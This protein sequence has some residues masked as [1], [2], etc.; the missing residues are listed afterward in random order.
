M[1]GRQPLRAFNARAIRELS[2]ATAN[3][4]ALVRRTV[5]RS[6]LH[7]IVP[8]AEVE[9]WLRGSRQPGGGELVKNEQVPN[10]R[11][12]RRRIAP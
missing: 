3:D 11:Q 5:R 9:A 8:L 12:R 7:Q 6:E 2:Q 10:C 1:R 4:H